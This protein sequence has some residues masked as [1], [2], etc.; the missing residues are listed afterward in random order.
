MIKDRVNRVTGARVIRTALPAEAQDIAALHARSRAT[1]HPEGVPDDG[2][3]WET[4]WRRAIER[5]D[6]HVLCAVEHSRIIGVASFRT[7]DGAPTD[8]VHLT[9]FHIAPDHRRR[10]TGRAL[11]AAC[12]EEWLADGKRTATLTVRTDNHRARAFCTRLGWTPDPRTP[13]T[14][15]PHHLPLTYTVSAVAP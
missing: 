6:G 8:T 14:P 4:T 11:H 9:Q 3:D 15:G 13:S 1:Y 12:V 10:G 7:T 2:T 5:P